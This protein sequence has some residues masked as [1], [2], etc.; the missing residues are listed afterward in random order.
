[1]GKSG[2]SVQNGSGLA[3]WV[4]T[5]GVLTGSEKAWRVGGCGMELFRFGLSMGAGWRCTDRACR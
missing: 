3:R 5:G 4:G 1:M 2:G